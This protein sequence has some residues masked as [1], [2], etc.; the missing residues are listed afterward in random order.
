MPS[1][2]AAEYDQLGNISVELEGQSHQQQQGCKMDTALV[3]AEADPK[4]SSYWNQVQD[5]FGTLGERGPL[6]KSES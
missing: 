5:F 4:V 2:K 1:R 6:L 3:K